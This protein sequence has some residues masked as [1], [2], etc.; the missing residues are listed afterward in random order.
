[1]HVH[2]QDTGGLL[3]LVALGAAALCL[4]TENG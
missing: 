1:M 3:G 4:F 2:S